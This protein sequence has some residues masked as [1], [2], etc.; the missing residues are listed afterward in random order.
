MSNKEK[1]GKAGFSASK[2]VLQAGLYG[3]QPHIEMI[4]NRQITVEGTKGI[5]KYT[6]DLI[7]LNA[8][9]VIISFKGRNLNVRCISP[10]CT[11][12]EGFVDN[13]EFTV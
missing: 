7:R 3:N 1:R 11:M 13:I 9:A 5:L 6:A 12:V 8:G 4:G 2:A 10:D